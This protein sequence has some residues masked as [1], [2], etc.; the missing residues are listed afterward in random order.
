MATKD[1]P[2]VSTLSLSDRSSESQP[3]FQTIQPASRNIT[4]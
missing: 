1:W 2:P 3:A 4:T